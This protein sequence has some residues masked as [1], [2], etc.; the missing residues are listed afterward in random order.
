MGRGL[1]DPQLVFGDRSAEL[2]GQAR[3]SAT[4]RVGEQMADLGD[5]QRRDD[6]ADQFSCRNSAQRPWSRPATLNAATSGPVSHKITLTQPRRPPHDRRRS[7]T[8]RD[9]GPGPP[10]PAGNRSAR[11]GALAWRDASRA[12]PF[13]HPGAVLGHTRSV[14]PGRSRRPADA[15][16][17]SRL[18][19]AARPTESPL[20]GPATPSAKRVTPTADRATV[21]VP[22]AIGRGTERAAGRA[23]SK[24][25]FRGDVRR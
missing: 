7:G 16:G 20:Y 10:G 21:Q 15:R 6:Q 18:F 22:A 13:R 2:R 19:P 9:R 11:T 12:Q 4:L 3:T 5:R 24:C 1:D 23:R 17:H 8:C 14:E 25:P